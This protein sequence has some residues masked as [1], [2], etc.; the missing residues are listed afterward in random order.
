MKKINVDIV[1]EL[2]GLYVAESKRLDATRWLIENQHRGWGGKRTKTAPIAHE[3]KKTEEI[4]PAKKQTGTM[5]VSA[6]RLIYA[7]FTA[8]FQCWEFPAPI[9]SEAKKHWE[10]D[11]IKR[12]QTDFS[13]KEYATET[14]IAQLLQVYPSDKDRSIEIAFNT[15]WAKYPKQRAGAKD[16]A[17]KK[18]IAI[19]KSKRATADELLKGV[20]AYCTSDEV[21]KGFAKGCVAWLNDDR[22][23][24]NYQPAKAIKQIQQAN[25]LM[26]WAKQ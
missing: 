4:A 16:K 11:T 8:G 1:H 6:D 26:E 2:I 14:S 10:D 13:C 23:L 22:W 25:R 18:F 15:F 9:L 21:A 19:I 5:V 20:E 7:K 12:I 24:V 3:E 17:K